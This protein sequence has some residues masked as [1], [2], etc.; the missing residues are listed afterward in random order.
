MYS[1]DL[2]DIYAGLIYAAKLSTMTRNSPDVQWV[3]DRARELMES[4]RAI[5]RARQG[6]VGD[7]TESSGEQL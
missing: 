7:A 1:I 4:R 6:V 5:K 3:N 2:E